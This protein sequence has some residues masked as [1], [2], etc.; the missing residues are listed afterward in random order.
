MIAILHLDDHVVIPM[1]RKLGE[2]TLGELRSSSFMASDGW[3]IRETLPGVFSLTSAWLPE[4]VTIGGYGYS[5]TTMAVQP[6]DTEAP[7]TMKEQLAAVVPPKGKK[8]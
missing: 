1:G 7:T 4:P 3:E 8:R 2:D 6:V 5:Y